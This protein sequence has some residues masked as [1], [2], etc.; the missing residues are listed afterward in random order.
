[1][2]AKIASE[3]SNYTTLYMVSHKKEIQSF[4]VVYIH[5]FIL[6]FASGYNRVILLLYRGIRTSPCMGSWYKSLHSWGAD[7]K[8]S[9][10]GEG[11]QKSPYMGGWF[12]SLCTRGGDSKVFVQGEVIQKSPYM[13]KTVSL[14]IKRTLLGYHCHP[15]RRMISIRSSLD[16]HLITLPKRKNNW[17]LCTKTSET[18]CIWVWNSAENKHSN[19]C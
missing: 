4:P 15:A 18:P 13:G 11:T 9:I 6:I 7:S 16:R 17:F 14:F 3:A 12:K 1:M 8:V 5:L 19:M 10:N 2:E